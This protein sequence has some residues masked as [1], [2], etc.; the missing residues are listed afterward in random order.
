MNN[1]EI[2]D[3]A[4]DGATHIDSYGNYLKARKSELWDWVD[5]S[6][7]YTGTYVEKCRLLTDI[8]RITELEYL[9]CMIADS[10]EE[11]DIVRGA[12]YP[13]WLFKAQILKEKNKS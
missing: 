7:E 9:A 8:Q 3:N 10:G 4:P 5:G 11:D 13:V 2:L 12:M 6:W 1:Q